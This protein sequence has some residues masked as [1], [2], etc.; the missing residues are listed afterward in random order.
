MTIAKLFHIVAVAHFYYGIYAWDQLWPHESKFRKYDYGGK[1]VY[2]TFLNFITQAAYF[3]LALLNDFVGSNKATLGDRPL[4]RRIRDY[5]FGS[6][7][8]PLAFDVGGMFW[9]LYAIDRELVYPK[10]LD[11]FFPWWLNQVIHT[12]IMA[13]IVME[14]LLL[15]HKYWCR[16]GNLAGIGVYM[17]AYLT[18]IHV[19]YYKANVWVYPVLAI[20]NWPQRILFYIFTCSVPIVFYYMGEFLNKS[21]WHDGRLEGAEPSKKSSKKTKS[22]KEK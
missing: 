15:H 7:A 5:I 21:V 9:L 1:F 22:K 11:A 18:W 10:G 6:I 14:M 13:F 4:I 8:F 19:I 17:L 2:L 3:T 20:L 12:N 16:K